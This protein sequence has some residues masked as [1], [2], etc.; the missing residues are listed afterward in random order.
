MS[1]QEFIRLV[2]KTPGLLGDSSVMH[3]TKN[4]IFKW[5]CFGVSP[6]SLSLSPVPRVPLPPPKRGMSLLRL[7]RQ[8]ATCKI[9]IV[10]EVHV[11]W[12]ISLFFSNK[13]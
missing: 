13:K 3:G 6:S 8:R 11:L 1:T 9:L 10:K 7:T 5:S 4:N 12:E 2:T